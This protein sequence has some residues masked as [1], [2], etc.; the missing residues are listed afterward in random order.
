MRNN[1]DQKQV[2]SFSA[3][4]QPV[5]PVYIRF[6]VIPRLFDGVNVQ[7]RMCWIFN[8]SKDGGIHLLLENVRQL[9]VRLLKRFEES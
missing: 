6:R 9:L 5:T 4:D 1:V 3:E 8:Q 2:P 7:P